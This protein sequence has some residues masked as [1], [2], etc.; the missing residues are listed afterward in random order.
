[1]PTDMTRDSQFS[2][3]TEH[4]VGISAK[5]YLLHFKP[6]PLSRY[7]FTHKHTHTHTSQTDRQRS[8]AN[9][10]TILQTVAQKLIGCDPAEDTAFA[11]RLSEAEVHQLVTEYSH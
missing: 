3:D 1:M 9:G 11:V 8:N 10:R 4:A 2:H 7:T 6:D 5:G